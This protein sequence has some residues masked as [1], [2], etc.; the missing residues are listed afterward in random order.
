MSAQQLFEML[1]LLTG[2]SAATAIINGV[3]G[4]R[5]VKI[6]ATAALS[7]VSIK[8][9]EA[10]QQDLAE[11]KNELRQFKSALYEHQRWDAMVIQRLNRL[12][13]TDIPNPP[14]LWV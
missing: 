5:K 7:E 14:E 9:V 2:S 3:M 10:M 8:Q 4:R 6:D 1:V 13:D 11:A 12:G